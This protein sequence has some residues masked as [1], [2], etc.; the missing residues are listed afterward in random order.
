[1]GHVNRFGYDPDCRRLTA[2]EAAVS[3]AASK[4]PD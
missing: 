3:A 2:F 1:M 4:H